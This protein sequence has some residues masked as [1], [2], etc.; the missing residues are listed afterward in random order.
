MNFD[1]ALAAEL[2]TITALNS[3]V[4]PLTAPETSFDTS[5]PYLI[6]GSSY[7]LRTKELGGYQAGK[8]VSGEL[9]V[10]APRYSEMKSIT[11]SVID[12]IIS[13]QS[14]IIGTTGPYIQNITYEEPVELYEEKP[15]LYRCLIDFSVYFEQ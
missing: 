4:Y 1:E 15:K 3:R 9:N 11:S 13:F 7:G 5:A 8:A 2:K 6:Y 12:K 14:R 10:I